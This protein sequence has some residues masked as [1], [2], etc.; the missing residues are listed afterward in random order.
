MSLERLTVFYTG[1]VQG[2]G[3]RY[4][5]KSLTNG[6]D[7]TGTIENLVDGRVKLVAEGEKQE[8]LDFR[9]AVRDSGL[10]RFIRNE[11]EKWDNASGDFRGFKIVG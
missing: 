5:V 2:V 1:R 8:L 10:G 3:F 11:E 7:V 9:Q 4:T 6:Y